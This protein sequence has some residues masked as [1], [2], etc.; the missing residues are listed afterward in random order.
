[1]QIYN[2]SFYLI[3]ANFRPF[4]AFYLFAIGLYLFFLFVVLR[5]CLVVFC[6]DLIRFYLCGSD[7]LQYH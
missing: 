5:S 1:M 6:C 2:F 3:L 7:M 4:E